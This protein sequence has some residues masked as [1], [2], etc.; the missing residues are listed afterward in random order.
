[1]S[2]HVLQGDN[3][4]R[5]LLVEIGYPSPEMLGSEIV[6]DFLCVLEYLHT[7]YLMS[8][9]RTYYLRKELKSE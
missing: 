3:A 1:M 7:Q 2:H 4:G 6:S 5:N 9:N 8:A